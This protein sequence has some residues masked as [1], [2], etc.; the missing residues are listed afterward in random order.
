MRRRSGRPGRRQ[1]GGRGHQKKESPPPQRTGGERAGGKGSETARNSGRSG[2]N[3]NEADKTDSEADIT[4]KMGANGGDGSSNSNSCGSDSC[5]G[6]GNRTGSKV[7][8][9]GTSDGQ[10]LLT[11]CEI[12]DVVSRDLSP[13]SDLW[14]D[15]EA[16][17]SD[18]SA[19]ADDIVDRVM[20]PRWSG[21]GQGVESHRG[22]SL[23]D[24]EVKKSSSGKSVRF[25]VDTAE[26][27]GGGEMED[28]REDKEEEGPLQRE[29][30]QEDGSRL[31]VCTNGTRK[32]VSRDGQS[33]SL[34]FTNGDT[35][36]I[37]PDGTV[38]C[39]PS[40][41]LHPSV[42][43]SLSLSLSVSLWPRCTT[44]TSL[45]PLISLILM[46]WRKYTSPSKT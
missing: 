36:H 7:G 34:V 37:K 17:G 13:Q 19:L 30:E 10:V 27:D 29:V 8:S 14:S 41:F 6:D 31:V 9:G 20:G 23:P 1:P 39:P 22:Q 46:A 3:G 4:S 11:T 16:A 32:V 42:Y 5:G 12:V 45:R 26:T 15:S 18:V 25:A 21:W 44:T 35:K 2:A 43:L 28:E 33:V 24:M 40:P 38:V